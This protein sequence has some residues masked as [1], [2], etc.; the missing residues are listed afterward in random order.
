MENT[1][2]TAKAAEFKAFINSRQNYDNFV[3]NKQTS[4]FTYANGNNVD[5]ATK[6]LGKGFAAS[7]DK[8][9][10]GIDIREFKATENAEYDKTFPNEP[11]DAATRAQIN[12]M[13]GVAFRTL[14][15]SGDEKIDEKEMAAY[16]ALIDAQDDGQIDGQIS[17]SN[18]AVVSSQLGERENSTGIQAS[19]KAFKERLFPPK[20]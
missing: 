3:S 1:V 5:A 18:F 14:D 6:E 13:Y 4:I 19:L 11:M 20:Q 9:H 10:D 12:S 8:N 16:V 15:T 2:N 17:Y 7:Y